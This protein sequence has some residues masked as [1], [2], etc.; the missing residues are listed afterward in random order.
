MLPNLQSDMLAEYD[1]H[2]FYKSSKALHWV[3]KQPWPAIYQVMTLLLPPRRIDLNQMTNPGVT[4][5]IPAQNIITK[6]QVLEERVY[7]AYTFTFL[8]IT[9]A[10]Q[11]RNLRQELMQR[12]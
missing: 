11:D 5:C 6:K 7:S 3:Q 10:S 12:P 4:V 1:Q 2:K 8:F 9:K